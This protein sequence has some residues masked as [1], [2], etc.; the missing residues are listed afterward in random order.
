MTVTGDTRE[1]NFGASGKAWNNRGVAHDKL[2]GYEK[3]I[4]CYKKAIKCDPADAIAYNNLGEALY[5]LK[6]PVDAEEQF[7]KAIQINPTL[8]EPHCSLGII[9]T[10]E[11]YYEGAKKEYEVAVELEP[12]NANYLN[13]LGHIFGKLGQRKKAKKCFEKAIYFDPTHGKAHYNLRRLGEQPEMR[14]IM[15]TQ[16]QYGVPVFIAAA[17][18]AA[19]RLLYDNKLSG[20]EFTAFVILLLALLIVV[21]L[22]PVLK[23]AKAGPL[24]LELLTNTEGKPITSPTT[25]SLQSLDLKR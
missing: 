4:E 17:I 22:V 13:S 19:H 15:P 5:K 8:T 21:I 2:E 16:I 3:A 1:P 6:R 12:T 23:S 24:K 11:E 9:L 14:Y 7:R 20:A 18:I 10:D 25:E